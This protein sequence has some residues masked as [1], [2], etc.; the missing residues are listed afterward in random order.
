M[1]V[2]TC[3][4]RSF[5]GGVNDSIQ[6]KF[7]Q[8]VKDQEVPVHLIAVQFGELNVLAELSGIKHTYLEFNGPWSHSKVLSAAHELFPNNDIVH[9]SVDVILPN[10]FSQNVANALLDFDYCTSWPYTTL[11][12][13]ESELDKARKST[14]LDLIA[15]S[16]RIIQ[17]VAKLATE[18]P[19]IEWG[20]FE[21]QAVC[22][23][24][25]SARRK[26]GVNLYPNTQI[27]RQETPH[28][29]LGETSTILKEKWRAN[30]A[31]WK[32]WLE[33]SIYR[34]LWLSIFWV[35]LK[36]KQ[37][38][39]RLQFWLWKNFLKRAA[40]SILRSKPWGFEIRN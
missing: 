40:N 17:P 1:L 27:E 5:N 8:S 2:I 32:P 35:L 11:G 18:F 4:F 28:I 26:R 31:R 21:H 22:F 9:T 7:I 14:C 3:S 25:L 19:N 29:E 16:K 33:V 24:Y 23:A 36:F 15:F 38:P 34:T 20:I 6:R 37:T 39:F 12:L 10:D 30:H 13:H